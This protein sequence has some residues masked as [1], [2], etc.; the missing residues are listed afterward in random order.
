MSIE[1]S[2]EKL[3]QLEQYVQTTQDKTIITKLDSALDNFNEYDYFGTEGQFDPRGDQRDA[4][5]IP[6]NPDDEDSDGEYEYFTVTSVSMAIDCI[7]QLIKMVRTDASKGHTEELE[8][9]VESCFKDVFDEYG[10]NK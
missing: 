9:M 1:K 4:E 7:K 8:S 2:I 3:E 6:Y 10:L 5:F